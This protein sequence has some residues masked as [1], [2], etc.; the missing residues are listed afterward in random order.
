VRPARQEPMTAAVRPGVD[1]RGSPGRRACHHVL[2]GGGDRALRLWLFVKSAGP[3]L[4]VF[5]ADSPGIVL[6]EGEGGSG[7][8]KEGEREGLIYVDK[9]RRRNTQAR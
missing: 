7:G 6:R 8:K 1:A 4:R 2:R 9:N 5:T 3:E